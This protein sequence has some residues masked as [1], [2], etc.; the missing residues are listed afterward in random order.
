MNYFVHEAAEKT[1]S[2]YNFMVPILLLALL[3]VS[4]QSLSSSIDINTS[5]SEYNIE[6]KWVI[7]YSKSAETI[8]KSRSS[9]LDI[10]QVKNAER[11]LRQQFYGEFSFNN[12]TNWNLYYKV[13][14]KEQK[15]SGEYKV[16]DRSNDRLSLIVT[17]FKDGQPT[18]ELPEVLL[19]QFIEPNLILLSKEGDVELPPL[20]FQREIPNL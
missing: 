18:N 19:I 1:K 3:S 2:Y 6:G 13:N 11:H 8:L 16:R 10:L 5:T 17:E 9:Q 12:S 7:H 15:G 4:C 20:V 14:N